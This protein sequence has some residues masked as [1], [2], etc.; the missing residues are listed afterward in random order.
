MHLTANKVWRLVVY[1]NCHTPPDHRMVKL[2]GK[3]EVILRPHFKW[4]F[5]HKLHSCRRNPNQDPSNGHFDPAHHAASLGV[6]SQCPSIAEP[7]PSVHVE[8]EVQE[9]VSF[10][11]PEL[12]W[13]SSHLNFSSNLPFHSHFLWRS[14]PAQ[15]AGSP[16]ERSSRQVAPGSQGLRQH[17]WRLSPEP[18]P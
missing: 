9:V 13:L 12:S 16:R 14:T 15:I 7:H 6:G 3:K 10:R 17:Q 18:L 8:E 1:F 11:A 2:Q 4:F 5:N